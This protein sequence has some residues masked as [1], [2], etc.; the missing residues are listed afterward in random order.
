[1]HTDQQLML[2]SGS[3][4]FFVCVSQ[5]PF[6]YAFYMHFFYLKGL[7]GTYVWKGHKKTL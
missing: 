2:I 5:P 7:D 3:Q 1:M 4:T 6:A